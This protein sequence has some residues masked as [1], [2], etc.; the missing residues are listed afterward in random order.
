MILALA[1]CGGG[2]IVEPD[3][4]PAPDAMPDAGH[5]VAPVDEIGVQ[6]GAPLPSGQWLLVNEWALP[7]SVFALDPTDLGGAR[8]EV[9]SVNRSWSM[10]AAADGSAIYFSSVDPDQEADFGL[11]IGDA[12][13]NTFRYVPATGTTTMLAPPGADW[14]NI[15]DEC[16]A[17]TADGVHVYICRRYDFVDDPFS[18][19]GWR[20]GR[21]TVADGSFEFLRPDAPT[22]PYELGP[23]PLPGNRLLYEQVA[24]PPATGR[25]L[26][27][28][29]LAAGT[30]TMVRTTASRPV[31]APD[32]HTV[33]FLD[34]SDQSR[35]WQLDLDAP[36]APAIAVS[37]TLGVGS[38]VWAPD[39]QTV[40]YTIYDDAN[41]CD[42]IERVTWNGSAWSTPVR[43]RDCTQTGEF[44]VDLAWVTVP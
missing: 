37:P 41:V 10:G 35:L 23:Q 42:H 43:D 36:A 33:L 40:V 18:F 17:P 8:R 2:S 13:Q 24:R 27:T 38:A 11:T 1:A 20:V 12:V 44:I 3:A 22:G 6:A 7:D 19:K 21:Y 39:Q 29:D 9:F 28:R 16:H 15:N 31:V 5:P 34:T 32:G 26:W 14:T 25:S 30:E 4:K